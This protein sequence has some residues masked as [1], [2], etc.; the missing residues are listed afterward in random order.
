MRRRRRRKRV[1]GDDDQDDRIDGDDQD[2]RI[3]GD[4][5]QDDRIDGD[6]DQDD[7]YS[8]QSRLVWD[9]LPY[10]FHIGNDMILDAMIDRVCLQ[11]VY[12][13]ALSDMA[14]LPV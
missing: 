2:D 14:V 13:C 5:D 4:D 8:M 6:D 12:M 1:G 7:A 9:P 11:Y 10:Q 3:D